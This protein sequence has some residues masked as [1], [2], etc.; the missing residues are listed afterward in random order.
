[1]GSMME[2]TV[3]LSAIFSGEFNGKFTQAAQSM[4]RLQERTRELNK[5][6][7]NVSAYQRQNASLDASRQKLDKAQE[8]VRALRVQ[9]SQ[10]QNPTMKLRTEFSRANQ[11]VARLTQQVQDQMNKLGGLRAALQ[12]AGVDTNNLGQAQ[13]RLA[14]E[15]NQA[16][17]AQERLTQAQG[18]Y[19]E[20]MSQLSW[21]NMKGDVLSSMGMISAFKEPLSVNMEINQ[22]L[23]DV[24]AVL[25]PT[26]QEFQALREQ[27]LE[28]GRTTQFTAK[29]AA[30]SQEN[31]A[32]AGYKTVDIL[33]MMP[34]VL[35][36]AA[37]DGMELAQSAEII[38]GTLKGY[39]GVLKSS[40]AMR[41]ADMLTYISANSRTNV[42][43]AGPGM[44]SMSGS[45]KMLKI[46]PERL[47]A[48]MAV[49]AN[50]GIKGQEAA[51]T[52]DR[53]FARL[54]RQPKEVAEALSKYKIAYQTRGG[55][56]RALE[57]I[58]KEL[59]TKTAKGGTASQ[60]K[61]FANVFGANFGSNMILFT[62]GVMSGDFATQYQGQRESSQ[63]TS[64]NMA[65]IRNDT[66]KGDITSLSS[67]WEGFMNRVGQ[68]LEAT[69]RNLVQ[70][71]TKALNTITELAEKFGPLADIGVQ[72]VAGFAGLKV[73]KTAWKYMKLLIELPH[74]IMALNT[75]Q[76]AA[77]MA[78]VAT[79]AGTAL[80][81]TGGLKGAISGMLGPLGLLAGAVL[82][83]AMN[84]NKV[85]ESCERA[86]AAIISIDRTVPAAQSTPAVKAV[87][88]MESAF[89]PPSFEVHATGGIMTRPHLGLV[90]EA[91]PEAIIPL[92]DKSRGLQ[93]LHQAMG[94][95]G[96][97]PVT[98]L[99]EL[100][101]QA[102]NTSSS[103]LMQSMTN[104][105]RI[106]EVN[107]NLSGGIFSLI[108]NAW[109]NSLSPLD[110]SQ[111]NTT[112]EAMNT[113]SSPVINI[114]V[115]TS[116]SV[117]VQ[118]GQDIAS[119]IRDKVL[120]AWNELQERQERLSFA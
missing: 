102:M 114:T 3:Q 26:E 61:A 9:M 86:G 24:K 98:E 25:Q 11:D 20:I 6:A 97:S 89:S 101:G 50:Q 93:V 109:S 85:K 63:G 104:S 5:V 74:A 99:P 31:L 35:S 82:L 92:R 105:N 77:G 37:A 46:E 51:T 38:A 78:E 22:A 39:E 30:S 91:G 60:R 29:Q 90:A 27:A 108:R 66:L 48:Y 120:E 96:V 72:L 117:E 76:T 113:S 55:D 15:L 12:G 34:A 7:G 79:H 19:N 17:A 107:S 88:T 118:E 68:P 56:F 53:V 52:L 43:E 94:Y 2:F 73:I 23:A 8:R 32:R 58:V 87:R 69:A 36:M 67:A 116:G 14:A 54:S 112:R 18:R 33:N 49:M 75:A 111:V 100:T 28:L 84:W 103:R 71:L 47:S 16:R 64:Q 41:V 42:A 80:A 70:L 65:M 21:G 57:D 106:S 10:T 44:I 95:L 62:Q 119:M 40:D 4:Q 115:N 110:V 59:Y 45:A 13:D 83:V 1:M 81:S